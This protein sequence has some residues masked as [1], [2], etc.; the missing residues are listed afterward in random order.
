[1][2]FHVTNKHLDYKYIPLSV[3]CKRSDSGPGYD[4]KRHSWTM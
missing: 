4:L 2:G 1:M 3:A